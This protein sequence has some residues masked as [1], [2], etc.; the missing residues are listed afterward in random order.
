MKGKWILDAFFAK[1]RQ[2]H[3]LRRVALK[4]RQYASAGVLILAYHRVTPSAVGDRFGVRVNVGKFKNQMR[5]LH[6]YFDVI[7]MSDYMRSRHHLEKRHKPQVIVTFDDGYY[8]NLNYA[9]P[10]LKE[11]HIPA[12]VYV[13]ADYI[14]GKQP[15]WWDEV[16]M[17]VDEETK[18]H[19]IDDNTQCAEKIA[20]QLLAQRIGCSTCD[21]IYGLCHHFR[22]M[23]AKDRDEQLVRLNDGKRVV[24][25]EEDRPLTWS[26]VKQ[27][28][29]YGI[30]VGSHG[31]SHCTFSEL[32]DQELKRE[33]EESKER[34]EGSLGRSITHFSYP[35]DERVYRLGQQSSR[36]CA[37]A[38]EAGYESAVT[39]VS[40]VN[41]AEQVPWALKRLTVRNWDIEQFAD[42]VCNVWN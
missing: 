6:R 30:E 32:R 7:S 13:A 37:Y 25:C 27:L 12:I 38:K 23:N 22:I 40:G 1:W 24:A 26:E 15:F 39:V 16:A 28:L 41:S 36:S 29:K 31:C 42:E 14:D 33:F 11:C 18:K 20:I 3:Y 19:G 5:Y 17:A 8:D 9:A 10:I 4:T 35:F 21:D 2:Y 34:I